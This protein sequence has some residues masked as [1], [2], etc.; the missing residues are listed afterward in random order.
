MKILVCIDD[1]DNIDSIGTGDIAVMITKEITDRGW[2]NT[3]GV[4]RH[5]LLIHPDV[6]YTSH[7]SSMCFV[8]D[9]DRSCLDSL[10][11]C[12]GDLLVRESAEG[13]D[14]GLCI[15]VVDR[16]ANPEL[17]IEFGRKAKEAVLTKD[18]A[19]SMAEQLGVHLSEHGGT[20]Q[21]VIGALA[22][23]GLRLTGND[24][25]FKGKHKITAAENIATVREILAQTNIDEVRTIEGAVLDDEVKVSLGD[26]VKSVL[27]DNRNVLLVCP[28]E[29][30]TDVVKWQVCS[31]KYL[32]K[33]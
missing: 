3:E 12:C 25:R 21:G 14:P 2:G 4:T 9:V 17:L 33:H 7:N 10:T 16:L 26:K 15:T 13:S 29:N 23:V 1:T 27:L 5:Q 20:G 31:M 24:G 32:K 22:G 11:A 18:E 19:Y 30:E 6:P 28:A 8:A